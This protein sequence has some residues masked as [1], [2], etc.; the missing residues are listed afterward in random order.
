MATEIAQWCKKG[1]KILGMQLP[2]AASS[3]ELH[4]RVRSECS[5]APYW[6]IWDGFSMEI[7]GFGHH[8]G[9]MFDAFLATNLEAT[10][11]ACHDDVSHAIRGHLPTTP[12][13]APFS[14][15]LWRALLFKTYILG[16]CQELPRAAK[17]CQE[18]K[19]NERRLLN[20]KL[21]FADHKTRS[22]ATNAS[23]NT[24]SA[25]LGFE[26]QRRVL[27]KGCA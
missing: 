14:Q 24:G 4:P 19:A 11:A 16:K 17:S 26:Q 10:K 20:Y 7:N 5:W 21:R 3:A 6:S 15:Y 18:P 23:N 27:R 12:L 8:F 25:D 9:S 2:C 22:S 1:R 13:G